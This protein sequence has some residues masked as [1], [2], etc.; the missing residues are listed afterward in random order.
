MQV[1]ATTLCQATRKRKTTLQESSA[2]RASRVASQPG[3]GAS[4]HVIR[5]FPFSKPISA[6]FPLTL[7]FRHSAS[8]LRTDEVDDRGNDQGIR[9][10]G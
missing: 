5:P 1:R 8:T 2:H 6:A 4:C 7:E 9:F 10:A 3:P